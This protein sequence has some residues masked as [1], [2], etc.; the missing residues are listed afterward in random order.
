VT[1]KLSKWTVLLLIEISIGVGSVAAVLTIDPVSQCTNASTQGSPQ[2][3]SVSL[4]VN[5]GNSSSNQWTHLQVAE[6]T[7][8]YTGMQLAGWHLQTRNYGSL[9]VFILGINGVEQSSTAGSYWQWYYW[10]VTRWLLGPVGASSYVLN[11]NDAVLWYLAP[12]NAGPPPPLMM[13]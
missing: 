6:C 2:I 10:N 5:Y 12:P 1:R 13:K 11:N 4:G 7:T 8:L 9:G 3:I